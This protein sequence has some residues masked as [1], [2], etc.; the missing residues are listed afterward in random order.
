MNYFWNNA[1]FPHNSIKEIVA[2]FIDARKMILDTLL[3]PLQPTISFFLFLLGLAHIVFRRKILLLILTCTPVLLHLFL[4]AFHLYPFLAYRVIL[5]L[6]PCFIL[7]LSIG[8]DNLVKTKRN[9]LIAVI[10]P[11][12]LL[13][14][15]FIGTP[16]NRVRESIKYIQENIRMDEGVYIYSSIILIYE[17]YQQTGITA[18]ST[19][20]VEGKYNADNKDGSIH[21]LDDLHGKNWLL[22]PSEWEEAKITNYLDSMGYSRLEE[23]KIQGSSA[24][25]YDFGE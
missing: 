16:W 1:F 17:Y 3:R 4:S 13:S 14:R 2:F 5:Y 21:E 20:V 18:I 11:A 7:I 25:L 24:Y 10:I 6:T 8:F 15:T 19:N 22:L 12:M 9:W 23:H